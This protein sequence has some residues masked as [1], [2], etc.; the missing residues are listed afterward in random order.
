VR[1][2]SS[3]QLQRT[4]FFVR[5]IEPSDAPAWFE[6]VS[7]PHVM[8]HTSSNVQTLDDLAPVFERLASD[9][10]SSPISFAICA[11]GDGRFVGTVGFHSVSALNRTAEITYDIHPSYWGQ[12][13]ASACCAAAVA[14]GF[15]ERGFV[16]IQ[17]TTLEPNAASQRVLQ[18]CGFA[19][20]GKLRNYRMVRGSPRDYL[21]YAIVP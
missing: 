13:I 18:K 1:P 9:D 7:L 5:P 15:G 21:L 4:D 3:P 11:A 14:W 17:G 20:E 2:A 12:G 16:R 19:L 10:P 8:Q 6:Y